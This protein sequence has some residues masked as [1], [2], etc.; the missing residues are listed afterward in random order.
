DEI[1]GCGNVDACRD[2]HLS[3][4]VQPG[5]DPCPLWS[6]QTKGPE[7]QTARRRVSRR[8]LRHARCHAECEYADYRPS[9]GIDDWPC[10]LEPIPIKQHRSREHRND[11]E[12][13]REVREAAH[14]AKELL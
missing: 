4:H 7:I 1:N 5:R 3:D 9:N 14:L 12:R 13:N 11:R 2:R 6:T 8:K 10:K